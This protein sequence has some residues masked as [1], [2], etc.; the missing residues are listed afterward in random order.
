MQP[1]PV[2]MDAHATTPVD[3]R[4]LDAMLPF[5]REAF[6]NA[7]SRTHEYGH[8]AERAV[9]QARGQ[10]AAA[11][12]GSAREIVWTAGATESDNLAILGAAAAYRD[13]GDHIVTCVT[14]HPAVLDP[15]R[16]LEARGF[17]VTY[18]PVDS[19]G[20]L[21]LNRL[22]DALEDRTILVSLMAANNEVGTLHPVREIA[23]LVHA[24]SP[25]LFHTDA[26]QAVGRVPLDVEADGVDLLSLSGHKV[27]GP[28]GVG[29]LWVRRR[30]PTVRVSPLLH[31]GGHERGL[32]PGTPNVPGIVGMGCALEIA[33]QEREVEMARVGTLRDRLWHALREAL[34]E[35]RLNGHPTKRLPNNLNVSFGRIEA[36]DLLRE[37]PEVAVSTGAACASASPDPSH[38]IA[39]LGL[40][41]ARAQSSLRFGLTRFNTEDEVDRVARS[42]IRGV[43][44]LGGAVAKDRVS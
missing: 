7:A 17:R 9:D 41:Q 44:A 28:K 24:K 37:I 38:V 18:L 14:E 15:C 12:S 20:L 43:G 23:A 40:G 19:E 26:V 4:V 29:A 33:A 32:R 2:Y 34:P 1:R 10:A 8:E 36:E 42:V 22:A 16:H 25:A 11:L 39:A 13:K 30:N 27:Y 6:G 5:F 35:A 21:D 3:P 31:G